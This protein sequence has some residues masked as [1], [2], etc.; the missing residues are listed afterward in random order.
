MSALQVTNL[1]FCYEKG[2]KVIDNLSVTIKKGERWSVI[3][4]NGS[5]KS[6]L[7][8]CI[9]RLEKIDHNAITVNNKSLHQFSSIEIARICA[10]VPQ[11]TLR[12]PP[13]YSVFEYVMMGRYPYCGFPVRYTRNDRLITSEALEL[14]DTAELAN[15]S[16]KNLSGGELQRAYIAGAVAQQTGIMLLDEPVSFLDPMHREMIHKTLSR[17]HD[18]FGTTMITVTHDINAALQRNTHVLALNSG[19]SVFVG[20]TSEFRKTAVDLLQK[21]YGIVFETVNGTSSGKPY[22]MPA[23]EL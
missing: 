8:R 3:G 17:I 23:Q 16:M 12:I 4:K 10:Y 5:G 1:S 19:K 9:A 20:T 21:I 6:T 2:T 22:Y 7:I 15:R 14:T 11:A 18:E 13:N